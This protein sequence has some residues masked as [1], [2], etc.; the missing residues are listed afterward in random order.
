[1]KP[2]STLFGELK[3]PIKGKRGSE[4][5][6]LI[7]FFFSVLNPLWGGKNKFTIGYL[8]FRLTSLNL[9]DLY[10]LHSLVL[11]CQRRGSSPS[12]AFWGSLKS[13]NCPPTPTTEE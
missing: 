2:I 4:R 12:S 10:Y 13:R 1:M 7:D 3:S 6:E 8:R 11:D 9:K 5:A